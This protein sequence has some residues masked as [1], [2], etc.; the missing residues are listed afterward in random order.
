MK[1]VINLRNTQLKTPGDVNSIMKPEIL[2]PAAYNAGTSCNELIWMLSG[3]FDFHP[4]D[5]MINACDNRK[6]GRRLSTNVET[7]SGA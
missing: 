3:Y 7:E 1:A 5:S 4:T 2:G 6:Y